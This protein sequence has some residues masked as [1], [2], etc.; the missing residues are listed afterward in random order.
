MAQDGIHIT[1]KEI[2]AFLLAKM[3]RG[4]PQPL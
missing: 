4:L 3:E 1:P 2:I